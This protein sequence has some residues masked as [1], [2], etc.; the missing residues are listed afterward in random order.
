[1]K[2]NQRTRDRYWNKNSALTY[3][4]FEEVFEMM[5]HAELFTSIQNEHYRAAVKLE[6]AGSAL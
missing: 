4:I 2:N 1:V 6:T 3:Q 5:T